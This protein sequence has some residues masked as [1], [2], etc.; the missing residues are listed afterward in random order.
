MLLLAPFGATAQSNDAIRA[1]A[2][3][4]KQPLL[5]ISS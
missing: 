1:P 5:A 4:E 2:Q 3:R